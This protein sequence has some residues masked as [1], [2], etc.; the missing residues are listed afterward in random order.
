MDN[1]SNQATPEGSRQKSSPPEFHLPPA[2]SPWQVALLWLGRVVGLG[3][4]GYIGD[5]CFQFFNGMLEPT[6]CTNCLY[7]ALT[8]V[9]SGLIVEY[10]VRHKERVHKKRVVDRSE[11]EWLIQ[12]AKS[13][14][15]GSNDGEDQ[16]DLPKKRERLKQEVKRLKR[17]LGPQGW[18]EYQVLTLD[19]LLS[20]FWVPAELKARSLSSLAEL[21]E[22]ANGAAFSYDVNL[23]YDWESRIRSHIQDLEEYE[24]KKA[25]DQDCS[26]MKLSVSSLR[27]KL[28]SLLEHIANYQA[29]WARGSTIVSSIRIC[30][31]VG[32]VVFLLMGILPILLNFRATPILNLGILNWGFLGIAGAMAGVLLGL[33]NTDEVEVGNTEGEK[34]LWRAVLGIPL[35]LLSGVLIFA[36]LKG[37]LIKSGSVVPNLEKPELSDLA[38]SVVWA[39]VSGL[40]LEKVFERVRSATEL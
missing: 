36:A 10:I 1:P 15:R 28:R 11:V 21:K 33:R 23:Y 32:V 30:G 39:V 7:V 27:A 3:A 14:A 6:G 8:L 16:E 4:L 12:E 19:C 38:L 31:S 29:N 26:S 22:Y 13:F 35:G 40:G 20:E 2:R 37:G 5:F 18:T 25:D 9:L 24:S 34:E 17:D